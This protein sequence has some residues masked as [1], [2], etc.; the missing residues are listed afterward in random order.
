MH[1][2]RGFCI[3]MFGDGR[4][5]LSLVLPMTANGHA[6]WRRGRALTSEMRTVIP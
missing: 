1:C 4:P 2:R 6:T 5:F 3:L